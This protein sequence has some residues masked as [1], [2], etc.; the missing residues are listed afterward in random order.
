MQRITRYKGG[1]KLLVTL[2]GKESIYKI[3][4]PK[5]PIGNYWLKDR[6]SDVEKKL[7][8]IEGRNGKWQIITDKN[9]KAINPKALNIEDD[10]IKIM[11]KNDIVTDKIILKEHNMYGLCIGSM[12]NFYIV[13]C[14]PAFETSFEHLVIKNTQEIYIGKS[15]KNH[16]VY[17]NALVSNIHARI[18][19]DGNLWFLE[20]FDKKFGTAVN[21]DIVSK[22][23]HELNSGDCIF[24]MGLKI[25][26]F[27]NGILI[28]NPMSNMTFNRNYFTVDNAERNF[29]VIGKNED[30]DDEEDDDIEIYED[31][32]YFSR[33]PRL[34]DVIETLKIRIDSP[35]SIESKD[36]MPIV[37][38]LG[39]TLMMGM[40]SLLSSGR[41]LS[42]SASRNASSLEIGFQVFITLAMLISM[43]LIPIFNIK[44]NKKSKK[45]REI[46]RQQRYRKY[47]DSKIDVID[48]AMNRQR[49]ILLNNYVGL[50]ECCKI[51]LKKEP[52]L[53][54]RKIEDPDFL[55]VRL[56][57]GDVP[58]DIDINYPE[59]RFTMEDDELVEILKSIT[60]KSKILKG[61]PV[62]FP[63]LKH[64]ISAIISKDEKINDAMIKNIILQLIT[65]QSY[66]ELKLVFLVDED[67]KNKWEFVKMLPHVWDAP[68]EI[69][70]FADNYG[71]MEKISRY[72]EEDLSQ[73]MEKQK[74]NDDDY[75][76]F[77]PYY[78]IITDNYKKI[79]DLKIIK[80]VLKVKNNIGF[81]LLC[82][83]KDLIQLPNECKT[84][85]NLN[86]EEGRIFESLMKQSERKE[87][88]FN[89]N[90]IIPFDDISRVL[91]NIPIK[92]SLTGKALL[93]N[94]YAFLEMYDV[95]LIEQLNI[96]ERW[97]TNDST[98]SLD[99]PVGIDGSGR[100]V[101]LD[102]HEKMHGPHGLIAGAT[103]SGKSEFII[104]YILSLAVNYHPYDVNFVL[105]DYKG[106]GLAG[107]FEKRNIKLPHL[108]GTITNIDKVGLNRS[109]ASIQSELRRRQVM[110]NEARNM[111]DEGTIDIYKYQ[112]LFHDG[113]VK[114]P[115]PHLFIICDEFAELKQQQPD[116]MEELISVSR[117]GRSLGVHL[118]LATQKPAGIVNE[119]IRSN[120]K[121]AICLKVQTKQ[122][123]SDV[124]GKPDAASLKGQGQ[125][126]IQVGNDDYFNLGQA[127][128]SG[129]QYIPSNVSKKKVDNSVEFLSNSGTV[130]KKVD[131]IAKIKAHIDGEQLT[132]IVEYLYN[133][134]KKEKIQPENLWLENIPEN[135]YLQDVIEKYKATNDEKIINPVIGEY[136]DPTNQKQGIA[137]VNLSQ[138]G[139]V[140]IYGNADSG[141][142]TLLSTICYEII[143]NYTAKQLWLYIMDF[144]SESLKVYKDAP[145]VGDVVFLNELEKIQRLFD[146]I[147]DEMERRKKILSDYSGDYELYL[148]TGKE[149][150]P[151]M[152]VILNN[153]EAF[154]ETYNTK[155]EETI[156]TLTREGIKY[157]VAFIF[158]LNSYSDMRYRLTQNFRERIALNLNNDDDYFSIMG[159]RSKKRPSN[160]FGRGLLNIED[161]IYEFQTAKI[162]D[163]DEYLINIREMIKGLNKSTKARPIPIL[164]EVVRFEDLKPSL[165]SIKSVPIGITKDEIKVMNYNFLKNYISLIISKNKY[166]ALKFGTNI[167]EEIKMLKN[168]NT[169]VFDAENL[170]SNNDVKN[171]FENYIND[172]P[173][174]VKQSMNVIIILG[175]ERFFNAIEEFKDFFVQTIEGTQKLKSFC[176][177]FVDNLTGLKCIEYENWYKNFTSNDNGIWV[178]SGFLDQYALNYNENRTKMVNN[179]GKS[180]GYVVK[181]GSAKLVKLLEM[182]EKGEDD[183]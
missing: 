137:R 65:F 167:I 143:R 161:E 92:Y 54:E 103:G 151:L 30:I 145:Q 84:F 70:F 56:G 157:G 109:L 175:I 10:S 120:S 29:E 170:N 37:L 149:N 38:V 95:G 138:P 7:I 166:D 107:A 39:S 59:D 33:A 23:I 122:D 19:R 159:V 153:F 27:G 125:F 144:G 46:K 124:I 68:K 11:S 77:K 4:L 2:I 80:E 119:Q 76:Q 164:P 171:D 60:D 169:I 41:N 94:S 106:G 81:G 141:K 87:F 28:N 154:N 172:F 50:E 131:D 173:E 14:M 17:K 113:V 112:K 123:S 49:G 176:Y 178:G 117:I 152:V 128:W 8:N 181:E 98:I 64:N 135:I 140:A 148:K 126:Y 20:N 104:T 52:R 6:N 71:D 139:N 101:S 90:F 25:I 163:A 100:I 79:Q 88:T 136:D 147:F 69:R 45:K 105:I 75:Q 130:I 129:A 40:I 12:E 156:L 89:S 22:D 1:I 111:T 13:Y 96:S 21:N 72:L 165:N 58:L 115:I 146:L 83:N 155:Y 180:F 34:T 62:L 118:I 168:V 36:E 114:K 127:A 3:R 132:K 116:F 99:A 97:R 73:R 74:G 86:G 18:F 82:L 43:V 16:I 108:V 53:W 158:A 91:A 102:I 32:E 48:E 31:K 160:L 142:E 134:A 9:V 24:I 5:E 67:K 85:I 57:V 61:A 179:C 110:F 51:V 44:Y 150:M 26:I 121:F 177:I 35:P 66:D 183:E 78:I 55:T 162:C 47:I 93:P 42:S 63:L 15:E 133:L 182:E 174:I